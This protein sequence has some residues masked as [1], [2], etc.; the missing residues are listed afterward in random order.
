MLHHEDPFTIKKKQ[1]YNLIQIQKTWMLKE[2]FGS[3][4]PL[5]VD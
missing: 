5:C 4:T 2:I 1:T 3:R